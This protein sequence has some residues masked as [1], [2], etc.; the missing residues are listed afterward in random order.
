MFSKCK[1]VC[2]GDLLKVCNTAHSMMYYHS[3]FGHPT[4]N[5]IE[6]VL[7]R[8]DGQTC[9]FSWNKGKYFQ[10]NKREN[11]KHQTWL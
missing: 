5:S 7:W 11:C 10:T 4:S 2:H 3:K 1:Q 6:D 8:T 9:N